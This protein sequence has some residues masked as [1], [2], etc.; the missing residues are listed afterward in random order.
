M[1]WLGSARNH[2]APWALCLYRAQLLLIH[3]RHMEMCQRHLTGEGGCS[4]LWCFALS[5]RQEGGSSY[6]ILKVF[7][8]K[9]IPFGFYLKYSFLSI[10]LRFESSGG[11]G[12]KKKVMINRIL[13]VLP[14][15]SLGGHSRSPPQAWS[16]IRWVLTPFIKL[17]K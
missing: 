4:P 14:M 15:N 8:N 7:F 3:W 12:W 10:G 2:R 1:H 13:V 17:R 5:G 16:C 6:L 9:N 11:L